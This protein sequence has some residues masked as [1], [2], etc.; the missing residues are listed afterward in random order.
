MKS[1]LAA[2]EIFPLKEHNFEDIKIKIPNKP[3]RVL[4]KL[5]GKNYFVLPPIKATNKIS[6]VDFINT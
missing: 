5:F 2:N 4:A 3:N 6:R 1:A